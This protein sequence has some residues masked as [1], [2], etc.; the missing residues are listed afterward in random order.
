MLFLK[1]MIERQN[2]LSVSNNINID[3]FQKFIPTFD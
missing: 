3:R 2:F 1:D